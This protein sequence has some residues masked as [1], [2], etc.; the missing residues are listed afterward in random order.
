MCVSCQQY[1]HIWFHDLLHA[2]GF[3]VAHKE[4]DILFFLPE[5]ALQSGVE[6]L[7]LYLAPTAKQ[8]AHTALR[9]VCR[10]QMASGR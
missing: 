1:L 8:V 9:I 6:V 7:G 2:Q 4:R 10:D 5:I 3:C